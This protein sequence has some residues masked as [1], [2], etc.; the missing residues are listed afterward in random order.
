LIA[1]LSLQGLIF[2]VVSVTSVMKK[3]VPKKKYG[4]FLSHHKRDAACLARWLKIVLTNWIKDDVFLDSDELDRL[5]LLVDIV[6][7]ETKNLVVLLTAKTLTHPWCAA[8]IT[9]AVQNQ[10]NVILVACNDFTKISDYLDNL[11]NVWRSDEKVAVLMRIGIEIPQIQAAYRSIQNNAI[12]QLDRYSSETTQEKVV[13]QVMESSPD[14]TPLPNSVLVEESQKPVGSQ[15]LITVYEDDAESSM[16]SYVIKRLL[17]AELQEKVSLLLSNANVEISEA[18]LEQAL[19][20][21]VV[22]TNGMLTNPCTAS[23]LAKVTA[24]AKVDIVPVLADK[25][26]GC[27][28]IHF[29]D[30]LLNGRVFNAEDPRIDNVSLKN[31]SSAYKMVFD[32][33]VLGFSPDASEMIQHAEIQEMLLRFH[34]R[35]ASDKPLVLSS[36]RSSARRA[37]NSESLKQ[38]CNFK[39]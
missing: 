15:I 21:V 20:L 23:L 7:K 37:T 30:N 10:T 32:L 17:Q 14:L 33:L 3:V 35:K 28:D 22:F 4:I 8:E 16:I 1:V 34:H 29:H 11:S 25:S 2:I 18:L 24:K 9:S 27:P 13:R 39:H 31:I 5:E 19:C 12:F 26:F 6:S 38:I 36:S